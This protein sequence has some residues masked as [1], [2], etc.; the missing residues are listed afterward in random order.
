[1]LTAGSVCSP[2]NH[3]CCSDTCQPAEYILNSQDNVVCSQGDDCSVRCHH[4]FARYIESFFSPLH[5]HDVPLS[6]Q[7]N[8][9]H[10]PL[11]RFRLF[12]PRWFAMEPIFSVPS[13]SGSTVQAAQQTDTASA[14]APRVCAQTTTWCA[15]NGVNCILVIGLQVIAPSPIR[16]AKRLFAIPCVLKHATAVR[17]LHSR[18]LLLSFMT[19]I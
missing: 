9:L 4:W 15:H 2:Y 14:R 10:S 5:E 1:M 8:C 19:M 12:S 7:R 17:L 18:A 6:L 3:E 13:Q 16:T 11:A